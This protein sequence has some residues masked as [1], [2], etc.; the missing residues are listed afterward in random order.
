MNFLQCY[1]VLFKFQFGFR[2]LYSTTLASTGF[3]DKVRS[4]L[5][6]GNYVISIFVDLTKA[7]DTIDHEILLYKLDHYGI[8]GHANVFLGH[9]L[10]IE[11]NLLLLTVSNL[12]WKA[13]VAGSHK[14]LSLVYYF[15]HCT[16]MTY[17]ELLEKITS[18]YLHMTRPYFL[19]IQT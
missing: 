1:N 5:D 11:G 13:Y 12:N 19:S 4:L 17:I 6:D 8:H 7:F 2:K 10:Q 18:V 15:L 3:T 14:A 9:I 16:L